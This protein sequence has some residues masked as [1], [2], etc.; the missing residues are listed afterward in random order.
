M[1]KGKQP[2]PS[3]RDATKTAMAIMRR[4]DKVKRKTRFGKCERPI[5]VYE[6]DHCGEWHLTHKRE[7]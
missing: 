6:C 3:R 5:D 7:R 4:R 1:C 2:F